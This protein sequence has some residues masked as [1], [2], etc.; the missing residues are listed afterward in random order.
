M[1]RSPSIST[2]N[3]AS[4]FGDLRDGVLWIDAGGRVKLANE[5]AAQVLGTSLSQLRRRSYFEIDPNYSLLAWKKLWQKHADKEGTVTGPVDSLF[6]FGEDRYVPVTYHLSRINWGDEQLCAVVFYSRIEYCRPWDWLRVAEKFLISGSWEINLLDRSVHLS[7]QM[8]RLV[9]LDEEEV[10]AACN[11]KIVRDLLLPRLKEEDLKTIQEAVSG[12]MHDGDDFETEVFL[13]KKSSIG[14]EPVFSRF[15]LVVHAD[16]SEL[17]V[18]KLFG[19]L[20]PAIINLRASATTASEIDQQLMRFSLDHT[21]NMVFFISREDGI[22]YA[23]NRACERTGYTYDELIQIDPAQLST[24]DYQEQRSDI[25]DTL[26]R[27]KSMTIQTELRCKD[28]TMVPVEV[29]MSYLKIGGRE[30]NVAI[31]RDISSQQQSEALLELRS[32]TLNNLREWV[33]WLDENQLVRNMNEAA[34]FA[35]EKSIGKPAVNQ[36][37]NT[38]LPGLKIP[39]RHEIDLLSDR[40]SG[41]SGQQYVFRQTGKVDL[42]LDVNFYRIRLVNA[43][44]TLCLVCR[45][46]TD[47]KKRE[48]ELEISNAKVEELSLRLRDRNKVLRE[49]IDT[50]FNNNSIVTVSPRY[51][52]VLR[53]IGQVAGTDATVLLTGETGTGKELLARS[54]H[55]FSPRAGNALVS[56][57]CA[58]LPENLIESELFGHEKGSFTGAY[59]QKRGKFEMADK[60]TIF[61]DE[62]GELPLDMQSKLLRVLQEGE[63]QRVGSSRDIAVDVRVVAATNRDLEQMVEDGTFR[64]DLFYRLNVF[65]I[66]NLPL[67]ERRE[68]IPVL[69]KH[70]TKQLSDRMGKLITHI[71]QED[72]TR[73]QQYNFPGNV[74]ELINLVERAV[75][76]TR[77]ET[78][79][80]AS[81]FDLLR[82]AGGPDKS[83]KK[84]RFLPFEEMQREYIVE[85]LRRTNGRVTGPKGAAKLLELNGRTLMSKM[86]KLGIERNEFS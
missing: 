38:V 59:A 6:T 16:Q 80:L 10:P 23:N 79:D 36:P 22:H 72:M 14:S 34:Q 52:G 18:Y 69:I 54:I 47:L 67:R 24:P 21:S 8:R 37:L 46:I 58:A 43:S 62:I 28:G 2:D 29:A 75:I 40:D 60:G 68:D 17:S 74:R 83:G 11:W 85:A 84:G 35:L 53:Q 57:N 9:E 45:D 4:V 1:T 26:R 13:Q 82:R 50:K 12:A 41:Q 15:R 51:R 25:Y 42:V 5:R 49:E 76:V 70:F 56:V 78:L 65:P 39:D 30:F 64:E 86:R 20:Q 66:H 31:S 27:Q 61:L 33:I 19:T 44:P 73:L 63:I 81:S 55:N 71:P 32:L 3:L 7:E 77:G 48:R